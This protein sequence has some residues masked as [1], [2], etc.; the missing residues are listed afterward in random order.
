V[1]TLSFRLVRG[2]NG[3][4]LNETADSLA[5]LGLRHGRAVIKTDDAKRLAPLW[6]QRGHA[7]Y[8]NFLVK[9]EAGGAE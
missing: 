6:A 2:H 4:P 3:H 5:K 1:P 8:M 7:D 9:Q